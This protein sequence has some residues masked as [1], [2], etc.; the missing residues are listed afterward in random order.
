[1][2][3]LQ[4]QAVFAALCG[5]DSDVKRFEDLLNND[6]D[7]KSTA[8]WHACLGSPKAKPFVELLLKKA[9]PEKKV[10]ELAVAEGNREIIEMIADAM[11]DP[12]DLKTW[13]EVANIIRGDDKKA[14]FR[15]V[16]ATLWLAKIINQCSN[17]QAAKK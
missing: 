8:I 12:A 11:I 6:L 9:K 13:K 5:E 4:N 3:S 10:L 17:N 14:K 15:N 7:L 16:T 1:M 2:S